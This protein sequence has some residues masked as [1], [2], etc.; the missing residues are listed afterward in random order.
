MLSAILFNIKACM[1]F[2]SN[3]LGINWQGVSQLILLVIMCFVG[4]ILVNVLGMRKSIL[5]IRE[6]HGDI[7]ADEIMARIKNKYLPYL[8]YSSLIVFFVGGSF[9]LLALPILP[10]HC[11][12]LSLLAFI[13]YLAGYMSI[14]A[15]TIALREERHLSVSRDRTS[16]GD[17]VS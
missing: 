11:V 12:L 13:A 7:V 2:R 4:G 5:N 9:L 14:S 15:R 3:N 1:I 6:Q 17:A 10:I 8:I 16:D